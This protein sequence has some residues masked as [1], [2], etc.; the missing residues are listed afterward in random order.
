MRPRLHGRWYVGGTIVARRWYLGGIW[1]EARKNPRL[2]KTTEDR[3]FLFCRDFYIFPTE[4]NTVLKNG[5][6]AI[7]VHLGVVLLFLYL[8]QDG[9]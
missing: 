4:S 1:S 7:G 8:A 2:F 9:G 6:D 5:L 3:W